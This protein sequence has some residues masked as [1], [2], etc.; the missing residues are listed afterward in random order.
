MFIFWDKL[1]TP[2][3]HIKELSITENI[4]DSSV[5]VEFTNKCDTIIKNYI[6]NWYNTDDRKSLILS[7]INKMNNRKYFLLEEGFPN[8]VYIDNQGYLTSFKF[9]FKKCSNITRKY[10]ITSL[11][12]NITEYSI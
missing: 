4:Y 3:L 8:L 12:E 5:K 7:W 1:N 10:K 2:V 6:S 9:K 11:L